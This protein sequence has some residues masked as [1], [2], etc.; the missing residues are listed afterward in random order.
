MPS[1]ATVPLHL[2]S[3]EQPMRTGNTA[4]VYTV[5]IKASEEESD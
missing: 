5:K 4:F 2:I 1:R 3:F